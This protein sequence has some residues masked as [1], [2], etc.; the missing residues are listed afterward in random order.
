MRGHDR[1]ERRKDNRRDGFDESQAEVKEI[2]ETR[3]VDLVSIFLIMMRT[4]SVSKRVYIA[5]YTQW[6][7]C[8]E[9]L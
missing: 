9:L 5:R 8:P 6:P 7:R 4:Q 2:W 3:E 1:G